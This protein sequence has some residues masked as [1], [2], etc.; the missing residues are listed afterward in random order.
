MAAAVILDPVQG[1]FDP[2]RRDPIAK[3]RAAVLAQNQFE[4]NR[5]VNPGLM[6]HSPGDLQ[7]R[8][9]TDSNDSAS[10]TNVAMNLS[11]AGLTIASGALALNE[12]RD[13]Y[14]SVW[15]SNGQFRYRFR[16][17]QRIGVDVNGLHPVLVGQT[18]ILTNTIARISASTSGSVATGIAIESAGP[19]WHGGTNPQ[20]STTIATGS[21]RLNWLGVTGPG[22]PSVGLGASSVPT[23]ATGATGPQPVGAFR[24]VA[25]FNYQ[26]SYAQEDL[27]GYLN[28]A[29]T[30]SVSVGKIQAASIIAPPISAQWFINTVPN[31][32]TILLCPVGLANDL[33][34]WDITIQVTDATYL[35]LL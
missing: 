35:P 9:S 8:C 13:I 21:A 5:I 14:T 3:L 10:A 6:T 26:G 11:A 25:Q 31:P 12:E 34:T 18:E 28:Q 1:R 2:T 22:G 17:V 23:G 19:G 32:N 7:V 20:I 4:A 33:V 30:L 16:T 27:Q 15:A 29:D 24:T